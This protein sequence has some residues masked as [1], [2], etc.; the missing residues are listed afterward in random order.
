[1]IVV[2]DLNVDPDKAGVQG[3]DKEIALTV[4][5]AVLEDIGVN[6]FTRQRAWCRDQITW[7]AVRQGRVV[8]YQTNYILGSDCWIFQNMAGWE[9][10]PNYDHFMVVEFLHGASLREHYRYLRCRTRLLLYPPGRQMRTRAEKLFAELWRAVPKPEK[11]TARRNSWISEET[12]RLF[13]ERVSA[14][15][16]PGRH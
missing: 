13:D 7:E 2:G 10:R 11:Q 15:Q 3:R 1:M 12:W 4:A 14:M 5:T 16:E 9:P 6:F 8:R